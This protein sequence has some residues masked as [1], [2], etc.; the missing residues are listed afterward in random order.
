MAEGEQTT[1]PFEDAPQGPL[2]Q[3]LPLATSVAGTNG[4]V[5]LSVC[6]VGD[7]HTGRCLQWFTG[8]GGGGEVHA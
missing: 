1:V 2:S 8:E 4:S 3:L 5:S 7:Q 6:P